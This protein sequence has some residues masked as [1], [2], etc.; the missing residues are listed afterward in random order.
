MVL[1][2]TDVEISD[3]FESVY[4]YISDGNMIRKG[5]IPNLTCAAIIY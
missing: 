2:H 1:S 5:S 4:N 3:E